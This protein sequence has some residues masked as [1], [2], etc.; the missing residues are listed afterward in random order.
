MLGE[1]G[2]FEE[3]TTTKFITGT[4]LTTT[5]YGDVYGAANALCEE[6]EECVED[7]FDYENADYG[8]AGTTNA[9][10]AQDI[11]VT[12]LGTSSGGGPTKTRNCSSL[13]VDMVGDGSLWSTWLSF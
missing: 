5:P 8:F 11:T 13:V 12:F 10:M 3:G 6:F 1:G 7:G 2:R 9:E 4:T